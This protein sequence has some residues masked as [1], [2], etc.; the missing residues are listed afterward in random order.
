MFPTGRVQWDATHN[1]LVGFALPINEN[2]MPTIAFYKARNAREF[3]ES[4][5]NRTSNQPNIVSSEVICIMAQ[6]M[7]SGVPPFCLGMFGTDKK[8]TAYNVMC[9]WKYIV[10]QLKRV[11]ITVLSIGSDSAQQYNAVMRRMLRFGPNKSP[12][13][14]EWF[15]AEFKDLV[16][17]PFQDPI[18]VGTKYR[19]R[20]L[21]RDLH[22]GNYVISKNHISHLISTVTKDKHNIPDSALDGKDRQN[23]KSVL[24]ICDEKVIRLLMSNVELCEGT[25]LYL[26]VISRFLRAFLDFQLKPL[27]RIRNIWFGTFILRIW[28][29]FIKNSNE[30][31]VKD[32]FITNNCYSCFEINSHALVILIVQ[33]KQ[34]NL[35]HL[36]KTELIGSQPCEAHF[37]QIRSMTSTYSTVVNCSMLEIIQRTSRIELLNQISHI[38]MPQFRFPRTENHKPS[39]YFPQKAADSNSFLLPTLDEII[40]EIEY[41]KIEAL[42]YA[43]KLGVTCSSRLMCDI[44]SCDQI[45]T[46][47]QNNLTDNIHGNS[48]TSTSTSTASADNEVLKFYKNLQLKEFSEKIDLTTITENSPYVVV[49]NTDGKRICVKKHSLCWLMAQSTPKATSDRLRRVMGPL[50]QNKKRKMI[51]QTVQ[52]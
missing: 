13:L 32:A 43:K 41:A 20:F 28:K 27:E 35:D 3:E 19:N 26:T 10:E 4:F 5:F 14:P 36:F 9:R 11:N 23:F 22:F 39:S 33:L 51:D 2:G 38:E 21:N 42:N 16:F 31:K 37:R 50:K 29:M 40:Q 17:L 18:H 46:A 34:N 25:V 12:E 24:Q 52:E 6:P 7:V 1:L 30:Y 45:G 15:N 47:R 44:T 48:N 8:F 49:R